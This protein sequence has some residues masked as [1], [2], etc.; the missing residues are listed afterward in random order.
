MRKFW[1]SKRGSALIILLAYFLIAEAGWFW[2][3]PLPQGEHLYCVNFVTEDIGYAVGRAGTVIKTTNGGSSWILQNPGV[4]KD[5]FQVV[6]PTDANIGYAVGDSGLILKTTNGGINWFSQTSG[7]NRK[8]R[9]VCFPIDNNIGYVVGDYGIILKTTNG[10]ST[11][12]PLI[13]GTTQNLYS[14]SFP[15]NV[16]TGYVVGTGDVV[17]KTTNGGTNWTITNTGYEG[18]PS[19]VHFPTNTDTGYIGT[20]KTQWYHYSRI[21]RTTDA[22][23]T[24]VEQMRSD[25]NTISGIFFIEST[26][27]GYAILHSGGIY[28]PY[29]GGTWKTTNGGVNWFE[30][31][32]GGDLRNS[33]HFPTV[34][35]GYVV[36]EYGLIR[37]TADGGTS[38]F[39][40]RDTVTRKLLTS[41]T[42][43][44]NN[45]ERGWAVG[46]G[47]TILKTTNGGTSWLLRTSGVTQ[48]LWDV[49]FPTIDTGYA[50]GDGGTIL[51]SIDGGN[52]WMQLTS[53]TT[54]HLYSVDFPLD[55][56]TGYVVGQSGEIRK[57]TDGGNTWISQTSG[58]SVDLL[59][60]CFPIDSDTGIA[61]GNNGIILKTTNGGITWSLKSSGTS[62]HL[63]AVLFPEGSRIG[64][65]VGD[66]GTIL[67]TFNGGENW[68]IQTTGTTQRLRGIYFANNTATGYVVGENGTVLK[69]TDGGVN[70]FLLPSGTRFHLYSTCFPNDNNVG[71]IVGEY[72]TI[73]KTTD[74]G[75]LPDLELLPTST[76]VPPAKLYLSNI[77]VLWGTNYLN[78][79]PWT[80][81]QFVGAVVRNTGSVPVNNVLVRF[82]VD[83]QPI[84]ETTIARMNPNDTAVVDRIWV[85]PNPQT[86]NKLV[87]VRV[88]PDNTIQESNENNNNASEVV[89]I[90]YA[91]RDRSSRPVPNHYDLRVDAYGQFRNFRWNEFDF[92]H[93]WKTYILGWPDWNQLEKVILGII[94]PFLAYHA[95]SGGHC[96]GMASTSIIYFNYPSLLPPPYDSTFN[97][98]QSVAQENINRYHM[99]QL[100][101]HIWNDI[102]NYFGYNAPA[103]Y[104][105]LRHY[106]KE[107]KEPVLVSTPNHTVTGYKIV[108][109]GN[110]KFVY[111]YDNNAIMGP[112]LQHIWARVA[113]FDPNN[114]RFSFW[115]KETLDYRFA[116]TNDTF[117]PYGFPYKFKKPGWNSDYGNTFSPRLRLEDWAK[118]L[119]EEIKRLFFRRQITN[120]K[121]L[122]T[123]ACPVRGLIIDTYGRRI[124]FIGDSLVNEIPGA[125]I[126][127]GFTVEI[128]NLPDS[129]TYTV[130]TAAYDTGKMSI[131][132]VMPVGDS[133]VRVV[134]FDTIPILSTTRTRF[135]FTR[136][137]TLFPMEIDWDGNGTPDTIVNPNFND[138]MSVPQ[139]AVEEKRLNG[140]LPLTFSLSENIPNPFKTQ[141]IIRYSLPKEEKVSLQIFDCAGR[142][143]RNLVHEKKKA[144]VYTIRWDGRDNKGNKVV[145]GVYFYRL[146]AGEFTVTKKMVKME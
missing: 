13:S 59:S 8:L 26:P 94:Y 125:S 7:T 107:E 133:L 66:N 29:P 129:L 69:T 128:Y 115:A 34:N 62:Q 120:G 122:L 111:I 65:A 41:V 38:W 48:H 47:G 85:L 60:V 81:K 61:V 134:K 16:D 27:T 108:E 105:R 116:S 55:A 141:T 23:A 130:N 142:S 42:F 112:N 40:Q 11:W 56:T 110:I 1:H 39:S 114:N 98:P 146:E 72:G 74:G 86:E 14:V 22:G 121:N 101:D 127:T 137:D 63:R 132:L 90:Y 68:F 73:L 51:K 45:N 50:V 6:F 103:Q 118:L 21:L 12:N 82:Y 46:H 77:S 113:V 144:G 37:K 131:G 104:A 124:G 136:T 100:L 19:Y 71:Y 79:Y 70:W 17:L 89:S 4:T 93:A 9:S 5:I 138:T 28:L 36:G 123:I 32:R 88:D 30:L 99:M 43:V 20:T 2:Q 24:W 25:A 135:S 106:I 145:N 96:Y 53:G 109:R 91:Y 117:F 54:R 52:S 76:T 75:A 10:G 31:E 143:V 67:K 49:C 64:Y 140:K 139:V 95:M 33:L 35:T 18:F 97:L 58:I 84:G 44:K 102:T 126:D 3:N 87:E 119:L 83:G 78:E 92:W 80:D 57:T 15:N